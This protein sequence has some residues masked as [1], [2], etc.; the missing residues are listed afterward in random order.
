MLLRVE[1]DGVAR[2][3]PLP[4]AI[5]PI[6]AIARDGLWTAVGD[7]L[8]ARY[9]A[10]GSIRAPVASP[11]GLNLRGH[12]PV[13]LVAAGASCGP[14]AATARWSRSAPDR[15]ASFARRSLPSGVDADLDTLACDLRERLLAAARGVGGGDQRRIRALVE[16]EAGCWERGRCGRGGGGIAERAFGLG[17]LEPLLADPAWTR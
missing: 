13:A 1:G 2:R 8:R 12:R 9:E 15:G 14:S 16:R 5:V 4:S 11:R 7:D 6:L 10:L 3:L 17:P